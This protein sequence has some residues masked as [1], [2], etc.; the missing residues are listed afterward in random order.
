MYQADQR[1][2]HL[3]CSGFA[4]KYYAWVQSL[5]SIKTFENFTG[6]G[7]Y[8]RKVVEAVR[9]YD[10]PYPY[11][12]G[13]IA[14]I[15][16]PYY[17][18]PYDQPVR[19]RGITKNNFYTLSRYCDARHHE[20]FQGAAALCHVFGFCMFAPFASGGARISGFTSC[21]S[22][23]TSTWESRRWSLDY[24]SWDRC[25]CFPWAFWANT[26]D[27][28]IRTFRSAR[29]SSKKIASTLNSSR[30][31]RLKIHRRE[32]SEPDAIGYRALISATSFARG[33][34]NGNEC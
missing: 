33:E 31:S 12:R 20:S 16:L 26:W 8:D 23:R 10:D 27:P 6:F 19:K 7:L 34:C 18:L 28:F 13:M 3:S 9:A 2:E 30:A 11:F 4:G 15:G 17:E 32:L 24:F 21:C 1:R 14:E 29:M 25:S 22:G 5:S